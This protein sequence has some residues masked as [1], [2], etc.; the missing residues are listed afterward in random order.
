[1]IALLI[2]QIQ[3]DKQCGTDNFCDTDLKLKI[4]P[5]TESGHLVYGKDRNLDV[6]VGLHNALENAY[7]VIIDVEI[8]GNISSTLRTIPLTGN[9]C[10]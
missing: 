9:S 8:E 10:F 4:V 3:Y 2:F 1:M 6:Q 7:N 5:L